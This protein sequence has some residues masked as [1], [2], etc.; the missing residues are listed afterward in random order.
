MNFNQ[1]KGNIARIETRGEMRMRTDRERKAARRA[2]D[3]EQTTTRHAGKLKPDENVLGKPGGTIV[4]ETETRGEMRMRAD[5]EQKA[6]R[7]A[8]DHGQKTVRHAETLQ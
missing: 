2:T 4:V 5:R 8:R 3:H 7:R 6:A 1:P